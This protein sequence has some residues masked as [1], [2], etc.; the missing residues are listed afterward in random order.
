M[1]GV[2]A[3]CQ[4]CKSISGAARYFAQNIIIKHD[5]GIGASPWTVSVVQ[6][7]SRKNVTFCI[8]SWVYDVLIM[9]VIIYSDATG[10]NPPDSCG[11]AGE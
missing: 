5:S 6:K 2:V 1:K 9:E 8:E 3:T 7:K 11:A 4:V 10:L